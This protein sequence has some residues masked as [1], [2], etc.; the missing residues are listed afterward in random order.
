MERGE[1]V[2]TAARLLAERDDLHTV[3]LYG[4][5]LTD[6][7]ADHS[8]VDVAVAGDHELSYDEL[9]SISDMLG[10]ELGR[11]VQVRDLSRLDGLILREVLLEGSVVKNDNPDFLG[12]RI[13]DMLDFTED[14]LPTV[15]AIQE[16]NI[17][18]FA[19]DK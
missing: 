5:V 1:I 11:E 12:R 19:Y 10:R 14:W 6:R 16:A 18:K 17:R 4:S 3:L 8:D 13:A 15:R 2:E 7:F 9:L